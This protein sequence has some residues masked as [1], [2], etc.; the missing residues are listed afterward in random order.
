MS[1]HLTR[2]IPRS[3]TAAVALGKYWFNGPTRRV[4]RDVG[5]TK[6]LPAFSAGRLE[7]PSTFRMVGAATL[8]EKQNINN[9][10]W[11][12]QGIVCRA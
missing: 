1:L 6:A 3:L 4:H 7:Q 10:W 9:V 11:C 8:H 5:T 12:R 2:L